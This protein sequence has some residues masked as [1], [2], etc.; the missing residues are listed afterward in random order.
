MS[1]LGY[2]W[3]PAPVTPPRTASSA[4]APATSVRLVPIIPP[5]SFC[6][7]LLQASLR[8]DLGDANVLG[9]ILDEASNSAC[10]FA[11]ELMM[12]GLPPVWRGT[13]WSPQSRRSAQTTCEACRSPAMPK[14]PTVYVTSLDNCIAVMVTFKSLQSSGSRRR[15]SAAAATPGSGEKGGVEFR[16]LLRREEHRRPQRSVHLTSLISLE[17]DV[18]RPLLGC[19]LSKS[20]GGLHSSGDQVKL[21]D[22]GNIAATAVAIALLGIP[23]WSG[24]IRP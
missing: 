7:P 17:L 24:A 14:R 6:V 12:Y 8:L 4:K 1:W 10:A 21:T 9:P 15:R 5:I 22:H 11:G 23:A 3:A 2:S 20:A 13:S 16:L 18:A 19:R